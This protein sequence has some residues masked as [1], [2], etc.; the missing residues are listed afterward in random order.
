ML[1]YSDNNVNSPVTVNDNRT[2]KAEGESIEAREIGARMQ[3]ARER[4]EL[5][6]REVGRRMGRSYVTI[7]RWENGKQRPSDDDLRAYAEVV[8][9][10][11]LLLR[12]GE[13]GLG[14]RERELVAEAEARGYRRA[15]EELR[16]RLL[17]ILD[18]AAELEQQP[19]YDD[20][21]L[22]RRP[23]DEVLEEKRRNERGKGGVT[24]KGKG[25]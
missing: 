11:F 9:S 14:D 3:K 4:A 10:T 19:V 25:A 2:D 12:H 13:E 22:L 16:K 20:P 15:R 5:T 18:E 17:G 7:S 21:E 1:A 24:R 8:G 23:A 6:G